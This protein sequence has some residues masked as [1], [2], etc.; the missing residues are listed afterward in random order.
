MGGRGANRKDIGG[1]TADCRYRVAEQFRFTE[2]ISG[3]FAG[4][5]GRFFPCFRL[6]EGTQSVE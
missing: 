5:T 6:L 3:S 1:E 2:S 4:F